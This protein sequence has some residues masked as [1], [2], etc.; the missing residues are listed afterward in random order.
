MDKKHIGKLIN[1]SFKQSGMNTV[2]LF[3]KTG[4]TTQQFNQ[5]KEAIQLSQNSLKSIAYSSAICSH[6]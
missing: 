5:L 6:S 3:K 2:D 1:K 4:I